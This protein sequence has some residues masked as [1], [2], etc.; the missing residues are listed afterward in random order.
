MEDKIYSENRT[1]CNGS[2]FRK[3][4][5]SNLICS[6]LIIV[7]YL[8]EFVRR[9]QHA[10]EPSK[11]FDLYKKF[12]QTSP[13][14]MLICL[15]VNKIENSGNQHHLL[16]KLQIRYTFDPVAFQESVN[17]FEMLDDTFVFELKDFLG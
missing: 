3:V 7:G 10:I 13:N 15:T 8:I 1:L 14:Q 16:R 2:F 11:V 9:C 17:G 4:L 6:E 12:K 5:V